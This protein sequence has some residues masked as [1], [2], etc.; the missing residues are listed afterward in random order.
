MEG[1]EAGVPAQNL[2]VR[3]QWCRYEGMSPRL[4]LRMMIDN[5]SI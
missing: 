5:L 2:Y 4:Y 3:C 1:L